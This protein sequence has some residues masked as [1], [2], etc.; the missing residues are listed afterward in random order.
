MTCFFYY[1]ILLNYIWNTRNYNND[2][3]KSKGE[4]KWRGKGRERGKGGE[5]GKE[6][7]RLD[8]KHQ[9]YR[10]GHS[11]HTS[12]QVYLRFGFLRLSTIKKCLHMLKLDHWELRNCKGHKMVNSAHCRAPLH[13]LISDLDSWDWV[14]SKSVLTCSNWTTGSWETAKGIKWVLVCIAAGKGKGER[15]CLD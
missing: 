10:L 7:S 14:L 13:K 11:A 3:V 1:F 2:K 5:R 8:P 6:L 15:N 9:K 4:G 12:V